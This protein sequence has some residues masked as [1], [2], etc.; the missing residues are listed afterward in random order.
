[1]EHAVLSENL[2]RPRPHSGQP[3]DVNAAICRLGKLQRGTPDWIELRERIIRSQLEMVRATARR[4]CRRGVELDDL[5]QVATVGLI[6][7]IDRF[8]ADRQV[9]FAQYAVPTMVGEIKRHFR[10]Q[11]W[12]LHVQRSMKDLHQE[13]HR[14]EPRLCQ[15]LQR[16]PSPADIAQELQ[17]RVEDVQAALGCDAAFAPRSLDAPAQLTE[18]GPCLSDQIGYPDR[19]FDLTVDRIVLRKALAELSTREQQILQ[20]R[21]VD[22]LSQ[23]QIADRLGLSQMQISRLLTAIFAKIRTMMLGVEPRS[24]RSLVAAG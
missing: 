2:S 11:S 10:D 24:A 4:F 15:R 12:T 9:P 14:I 3:Y 8:D 21:F 6:K 20:W 23:G 17:V 1:M 18:Q 7:A 16:T 13:I 5:I 19:N 22:N